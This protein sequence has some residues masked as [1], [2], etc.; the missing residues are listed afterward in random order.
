MTQQIRDDPN[1]PQKV[2]L[3]KK[4]V[5]S[6]TNPITRFAKGVSATGGAASDAAIGIGKA[7]GGGTLSA[8]KG[9][10]SSVGSR[11]SQAGLDPESLVATGFDN[12]PLMNMI[13]GMS[14][15]A[16][17][18][19]GGAALGGVKSLWGK[20]RGGGDGGA[21]ELEES[22]LVE[23]NTGSM[24][25][26]VEE[27][28]QQLESVVEKDTGSMLEA[29]GGE[30]ADELEENQ[31]ESTE[32]LEGVNEKLEKV[33]ENTGSMLEAV[34]SNQLEDIE[35]QREQKRLWERMINKM[36]GDGDGGEDSGI[37]KDGSFGFG[38]GIKL[39]G[40]AILGGLAAW[41]TMEGDF[42]NVFSGWTQALKQMNKRYA[43]MVDDV[44]QKIATVADDV[45]KNL[46]SFIKNT[47]SK[48]KNIKS[49]LF[50]GADD[51]AAKAAK[52]AAGAVDDVAQVAD[53]L[54]PEKGLGAADEVV[55]SADDMA[56]SMSKFGKVAKW[57]SRAA[58][59]IAVAVDAG[60]AAKDIYDANE[61]ENQGV[62][63]E[64]QLED[65]AVE[66]SAGAAGSVGGG[67]GGAAAGAALGTMLLPGVGT[68]LGGI[69]GGIGGAWL[70]EEGMTALAEQF[71]GGSGVQ[72]V[73]DKMDVAAEN[74]AEKIQGQD[75]VNPTSGETDATGA[76]PM[77]YWDRVQEYNGK[78]YG[79]IY[80]KDGTQDFVPID[81]E[82]YDI[83][84]MSLG[85]PRERQRPRSFPRPRRDSKLEPKDPRAQ[86]AQGI[87]S[88]GVNNAAGSGG[89]GN[90]VV[91]NVDQSQ[92]GGGAQVIPLPI[93]TK[94]D[95]SL[96]APAQ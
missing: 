31:E 18:A 24:L 39:L 71:T 1:H 53:D 80:N 76:N 14:M 67:L 46:D 95:P 43:S 6:I 79:T 30:G 60:M 5:D 12:N 70:G 91:N 23:E 48:F 41:L 34:E 10:A 11:I 16:G 94:T 96:A 49:K 9:T 52:G 81:R 74:E 89:K 61:L 88:A 62:L 69:V 26:A 64:E 78:L 35:E 40:V 21:D 84:T 85:G 73:L 82:G 59:P 25:E 87:Q 42:N 63:S 50:G 86:A 83:S 92:S 37:E 44:G 54:V 7:A 2:E 65:Y 36:K 22:Q 72:E 38:R 20:R 8:V 57:F 66:R 13:A 56:K 45:A 47:G 4:S 19:L 58:T 90:V 93:D 77:D 55:E 33:E 3:S 28:N 32:Q 51:A 68:L 17:K 75:G 15:D 27:N 29:V